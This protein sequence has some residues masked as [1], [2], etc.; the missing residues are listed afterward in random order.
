MS[1][2]SIAE[3]V[4]S[5]KFCTPEGVSYLPHLVLTLSKAPSFVACFQNKGSLAAT[6]NSNIFYLF[7]PKTHSL[8]VQW[9]KSPLLSV[10]QA[11]FA[12]GI[13]KHIIR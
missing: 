5:L 2:V 10:I 6:E 11:I 13:S 7:W 4:V 1:F 12:K 9:L 3:Y 8:W